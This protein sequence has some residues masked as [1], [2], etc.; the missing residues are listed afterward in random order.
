MVLA[1]C[2]KGY[3]SET[4]LA[5]SMSGPPVPRPL[6]CKPCPSGY[7]QDL[8]GQKYCRECPNKSKSRNNKEATVTVYECQ[9]ITRN[10]WN[11][12]VSY[13]EKARKII[14]MRILKK[15]TLT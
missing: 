4:G 6:G 14:L 15:F 1:V 13:S 8:E 3:A 7:F 11:E 12:E 9:G 2:P 5:L 10:N